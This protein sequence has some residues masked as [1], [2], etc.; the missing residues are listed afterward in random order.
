[1][2][3]KVK[4]IQAHHITLLFCQAND[5][6]ADFVTKKTKLDKNVNQTFWQQGPEFLKLDKQI[7]LEKFQNN[8]PNLQKE[9][10]NEEE[11]K[12]KPRLK[13]NNNVIN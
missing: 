2:A 9:D 13:I 12:L 5:N 7:I 4:V 1:M 3:N 6:P 11:K 8:I 10:Q